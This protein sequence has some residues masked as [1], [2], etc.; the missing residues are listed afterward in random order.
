MGSSRHEITRLEGFSDAVFG[1]ALTLLV[2]SLDVPRSYADLM[3]LMSGFLSFACCFALLFWIWHEHNTF[4]RRYGLQ[5]GVTVVLN[6]CLLFT[7]LF[8]VYPLKFMFDSMFARW[9]PT[10]NEPV[11]MALFELANASAIYAAGFVVM[12]LMFVLLYT[13]A[14][15]KRQALGLSALEVFELKALRG[16]HLVSVGVGVLSLAIAQ[17]APLTWAP[18]APAALGLMGP[19]H[20]LWAARHNRTRRALFERSAG[21]PAGV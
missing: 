17:W 16:H 9:M 11:R 5:D 18:F 13:R 2:V 6:G 12:M 3:A 8:Y 1:F 10:R 7:V 15:A 20:G 4:F 19:G 21:A 14:H